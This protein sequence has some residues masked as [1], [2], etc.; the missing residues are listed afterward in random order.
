MLVT[1]ESSINDD[2]IPFVLS[3]LRTSGYAVVSVEAVENVSSN[4]LIT[5]SLVGRVLG[6]YMSYHIID[7]ESEDSYLATHTE[8][9]SYAAGIIPYFSLGCIHL[10]DGGGATRIFDARRAAYILRE[11]G[12]HESIIEYSSLAHPEQS[13]RYPLVFNDPEYGDVLRY[14]SKVIT[15]K[16]ILSPCA[17]DDLYRIVDNT[18]EFCV[19][20]VHSWTKGDLLFVNNR[21]TL[22]DRLPYKGRRSMMR[23]RFDDGIHKYFCF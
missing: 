9:I 8:G 21:L 11:K 15:N 2:V 20:Y 5:S 19:S 23:M 4:L 6:R 12:V 13:A 7:G 14:R 10:A 3:S 1:S 16:I 18:L 22:H 17:E